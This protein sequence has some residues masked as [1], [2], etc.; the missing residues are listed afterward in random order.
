[1][2]KISILL[3]VIGFSVLSAEKLEIT[4]DKFIAKDAEKMVHFMGNAQIIQGKTQVHAAKIIVYFNED[5]S[6]RMYRAFGGVRFHI[7]KSETD[8]Q[9][10]CHEMRYFPKKKKYILEGSVKVKDRQNR[11]DI[12]ANR[13]E[14][15]STTGAFTIEGSKK[16]AAKLI[17]EMK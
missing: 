13:I 5:N 3:F 12:T 7:R 11:R 9:G 2:K 8:Y 4:A 16:T 17:F 14:I 10:S 6:T 15:H 1:M